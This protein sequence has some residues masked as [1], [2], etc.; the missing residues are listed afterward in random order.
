MMHEKADAQAA[1][2]ASVHAGAALAERIEAPRFT[3][4]VVA[5]GPVEHQRARYVALR[6]RIARWENMRGIVGRLARA[7]AARH[8]SVLRA[9]LAAIPLE[10]KWR[11][12][13]HN[14]VTTNGKNDLL[15]KY[16]SGSAYTA[17][18]YVG[19]ISSV[20]YTTGPAAGDTMASHGGWTEA[21][22]TNAPT[23]SQANRPTLAF[24]AAS[25]GSKSTSSASAFSIT[26]TGTVKGAFVT[27]S[28][29]KDGTTGVLY[30]A[31]LF[32]Q[33]DRSVVNG[34]T[35]NVSATLLV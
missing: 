16:F 9:A 13:F 5:V 28:N 19:L 7:I 11:E 29:T 1:V 30:S 35:L 32:T 2:G 17:A 25:G 23:Y 12:T 10:P 27:T 4:D 22:Q 33:G 6:D 20:S 26:S 8:I 31:G 15:D 34:D 14:V 18:W 21:G 24:A 3:Y